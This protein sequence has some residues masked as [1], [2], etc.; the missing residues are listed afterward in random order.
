MIHLPSWI[1]TESLSWSLYFSVVLCF[2]IVLLG[3]VMWGR[4]RSHYILAYAHQLKSLVLY[5]TLAFNVYIVDLTDF[6]WVSLFE[7]ESQ[8]QL[9]WHFVLLAWC[10]LTIRCDRGMLIT[11]TKWPTLY[12]LRSTWVIPHSRNH[13]REQAVSI[14]RHFVQTAAAPTFAS[15]REK[16][17]KENKSWIPAC[18][19]R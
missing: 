12:T 13:K 16:T 10:K 15:K 5:F 19:F 2:A 7:T 17:K 3:Y 9:L 4:L 8:W 11:R 14:A 6:T 1:Y 18:A